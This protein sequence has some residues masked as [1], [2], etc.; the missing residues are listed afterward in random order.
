MTEEKEK[1]PAVVQAKVTKGIVAGINKEKK[2]ILVDV[3]GNGERTAYI[4]GKHSTL[5]IG[6][7][8][9]F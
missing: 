1:K 2:Y 6:D 8:I 7:P 9:E 4:E 5:K 3:Q